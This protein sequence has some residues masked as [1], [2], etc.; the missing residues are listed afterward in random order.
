MSA[1]MLEAMPFKIGDNL[2]FEVKESTQ[3][4]LTL[5][6]IIQEQTLELNSAQILSNAGLDQNV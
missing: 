5:K 3:D 4:Q 2:L 6:P 1:K